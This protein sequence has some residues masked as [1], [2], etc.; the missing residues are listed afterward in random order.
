MCSESFDVGRGAMGGCVPCLG[1]R[2]ELL[3]VVV[4]CGCYVS[5]SY[6]INLEMILFV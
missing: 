1:I 4:M 6:F 3:D 2:P 5:L